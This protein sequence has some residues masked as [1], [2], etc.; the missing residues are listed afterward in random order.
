M[1]RAVFDTTIFVSSLLKKN[2]LPAQA[3]AAWRAHRVVLLT[4]PAILSEIAATLQYTRIRRKYRVTDVEVGELID[5]LLSDAVVVAGTLNVAGSVPGD[6]DD[7]IVL[8][9]AVE[10]QADLIVTGDQH[11]LAL[12]AFRSIPIVTVRSLLERLADSEQVQSL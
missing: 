3:L 12:A 11:L 2:G 7:E 9:C 8:A 6:P 10:G 1:I 4:S 5:L